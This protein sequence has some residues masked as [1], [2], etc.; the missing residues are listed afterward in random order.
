M[1]FAKFMA[2]QLRKPSG[3]FGRYIMVHLLN[4]INISINSLA[5]EALQLETHDHVLEVGFGGGDLITKLSR[6]LTTG[7]ITGVDYSQDMVDACTKRF[8]ALIRAG[9]VNLHCANVAV[10]PFETDTFT[11]VCTVNTIYF[12][13]DPLVVFHQIHRVLKENGKLVVCFS[14]RAAMENRGKVIHHGF[15]L[16]DAE[17]VTAL[18]TEAGFREVRLVF[19]NGRPGECVAAVGTK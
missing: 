6:V 9:T 14:T 16:Y 4:R 8:A 3:F 15:T 11:K 19:G 5:L 7:R 1:G 12:W 18:L 10:L 2:A 13:S 17:E